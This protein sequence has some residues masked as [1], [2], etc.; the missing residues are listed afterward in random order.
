M[1]GVPLGFGMDGWGTKIDNWL[2]N[3][4]PTIQPSCITITTIPSGC[5]SGVV[6]NQTPAYCKPFLFIDVSLPAF[7]LHADM[8]I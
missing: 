4:I 1:P 8:S 6:I 3:R 7:S 5:F 2:V